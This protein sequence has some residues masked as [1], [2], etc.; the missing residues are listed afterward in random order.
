MLFSATLLSSIAVAASMANAA[1]LPRQVAPGNYTLT[2]TNQ[3]GAVQGT[4]FIT[5]GLF[6]TTPGDSFSFHLMPNDKLIT[7]FRMHS[8]L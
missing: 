6:A 5:F 8:I 7:P 3:T 1:I 4:D 2:F